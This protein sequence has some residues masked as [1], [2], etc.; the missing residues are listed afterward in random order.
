MKFFNSFISEWWFLHIIS[1]SE[2]DNYLLSNYSWTFKL[3]LWLFKTNK[4]TKTVTNKYVKYVLQNTVLRLT[5]MWAF[6][7]AQRLKHLPA[8]RETQ[9]WSL[10]W[11]DPLEKEMA[12]HSS[13]L[14]WKIPWTEE[15]GRLQSM[16]SQRVGHDWA[17]SQ[18]TTLGYFFRWFFRRLPFKFLV[19]YFSPF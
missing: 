6:L 1:K 16:G 10:G 8:M 19:S 11:K 13:I 9:V 7:V 3:Q 2:S 12:T 14:A 5:E 15:P 18:F 17:T 4:Q